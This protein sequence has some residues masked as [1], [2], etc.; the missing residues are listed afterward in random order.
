MTT[1]RPLFYLQFCSYE[2]FAQDVCNGDLYGNTAEFFRKREIET[3]ERG[4][5]D[6]FELLLSLETQNITVVDNE[7]GKVVFTA[8]KGAFKVQFK[9][10]DVILIVSFFGIPLGDKHNRCG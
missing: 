5:G 8:P 7:T 3:G 1:P 4:Q 10:D 2:K 9:N 6:K